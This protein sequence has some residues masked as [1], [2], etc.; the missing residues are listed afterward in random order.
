M[1]QRHLDHSERTSR[2]HPPVEAEVNGSDVLI[3]ALAPGIEE[4]HCGRPL[5]PIKKRGGTAGRRIK[6]SWDR[7]CKE[8]SQYD[9]IEAVQCYPGSGDHGHDKT[10]CADAV[11]ACRGRLRAALEQGNY[12]KAIALGDVACQSLSAASADLRLE[13]VKATHPTGGA[14]NAELDGLWD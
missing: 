9:I 14:T 6:L 12:R 5:M 11:A 8:R 3:V 2:D 7:E 13:T 10:P 1:D 4:W